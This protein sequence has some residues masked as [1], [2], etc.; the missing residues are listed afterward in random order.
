MAYASLRILP[1][2]TIFSFSFLFLNCNY[3]P[4]FTEKNYTRKLKQQLSFMM[5][6]QFFFIFQLEELWTLS[7]TS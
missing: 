7:S 3:N 6:E 4:I 1:T 5:E 2:S